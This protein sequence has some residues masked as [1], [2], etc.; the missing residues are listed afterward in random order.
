[1]VET[2]TQ[3][4]RTKADM[5]A[6]ARYVKPDYPVGAYGM[7]I[8]YLRSIRFS[9]ENADEETVNDVAT[10]WLHDFL[11]NNPN[12]PSQENIVDTLD[13]WIHA[14]KYGSNRLEGNKKTR[15]DHLGHLVKWLQARPATRAFDRVSDEY[16]KPVYDPDAPLDSSIT[17]DVAMRQLTILARVY[18]MTH[19]G[20]IRLP[21]FKGMQDYVRKLETR[22]LGEA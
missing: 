3:D 2:Y 5:T 22:A 1:M 6:A 20:E 15:D 7:M 21:G 16:Q 11:K 8:T 9:L 17:R 19:D 13:A 10:D 14:L 4:Y 12:W 18:G